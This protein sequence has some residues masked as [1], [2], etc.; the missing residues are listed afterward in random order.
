MNWSSPQPRR[1][2]PT[3]PPK[4]VWWR[5]ESVRMAFAGAVGGITVLVCSHL[6]GETGSRALR[7]AVS[8]APR[9]FDPFGVLPRGDDDGETA[10]RRPRPRREGDYGEAPGQDLLFRGDGDYAEAPRRGRPRGDHDYAEAPPERR[11]PRGE[12][13]YEEAPSR[14]LRP[15]PGSGNGGGRPGTGSADRSPRDRQGHPQGRW[16]ECTGPRQH[17]RCGPW[18]TAPMPRE[19]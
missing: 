8:D 4:R 9:I 1:E 19:E 5:S 7:R 2:T 11:L 13:D 15:A 18:Q 3:T 6:W 16:K 10:R 17:P 14:P 12:G